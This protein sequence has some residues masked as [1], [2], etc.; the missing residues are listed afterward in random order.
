MLNVIWDYELVRNFLPVAASKGYG[1]TGLRFPV[2]RD[3]GG[4]T[5]RSPV[6]CPRPY[7]SRHGTVS[8]GNLSAYEGGGINAPATFFISPPDPCRPQ[9]RRPLHPLHDHKSQVVFRLAAAE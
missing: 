3:H 6:G 2:I 9:P 8:A 5:R 4:L 7:A 1:K